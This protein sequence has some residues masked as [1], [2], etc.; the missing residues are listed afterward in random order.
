[1]FLRPNLKKE[2]IKMGKELEK[3]MKISKNENKS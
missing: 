3:K 2:N 1:M